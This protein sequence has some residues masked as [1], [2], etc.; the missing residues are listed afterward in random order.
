VAMIGP[1]L[2][3]AVAMNARAFGLRQHRTGIIDIELRR[4]GIGLTVKNYL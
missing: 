4:P 3:P 2:I 1:M